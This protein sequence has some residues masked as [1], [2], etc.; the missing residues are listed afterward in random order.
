M[1][2]RFWSKF[3]LAPPPQIASEVTE[4]GRMCCYA[5]FR[6]ADG[7]CG[8]FSSIAMNLMLCAM[9]SFRLT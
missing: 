6:L 4:I 2:D 3:T 5:C 9:A 8:Q 7:D 1:I